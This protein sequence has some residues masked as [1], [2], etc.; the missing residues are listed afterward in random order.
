MGNGVSTVPGWYG[1]WLSAFGGADSGIWRIAEPGAD[2]AVPYRRDRLHVGLFEIAVAAAAA[3][4]HT[5]YYDILGGGPG[6]AHAL[7]RMMCD[8]NVD[9]L[10]FPYLRRNSRLLTAL[11]EGG[12]R[13]ALEHCEFAPFVDCDDPW[14]TYWEGRGKKTRQ[15]WLRHER[16]LLE[17][18]CECVCL[19]TV[20]E[21]EAVFEE[22]LT[23]E[24]SG[25]KGAG[26]TAISQ[27]HGAEE[28]YRMLVRHWAEQGWLRLFLMRDSGGEIVAFQL[29]A[30]YRGVVI[31]LKI[32]QLAAY[33]R[34]SP[35]QVLQLQIL[36]RLFEDPEVGIYDLLG[37]ATAHKLRW[38]TGR[39]ELRTLRIF[40]R[41]PRGEL[42]RVR[43]V[44]AP[45]WKARLRP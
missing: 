25:W 19:E 11:G 13:V 33:D 27:E 42:A 20:A 23:V 44:V 38:A 35:G 5:P 39:E 41:S 7:R 18:G 32:G 40:R 24:A 34:H 12:R 45:R 16:R 2:L 8:L 10:V 29:C 36:R 17:R 3:N 9:M 1:I 26:G 43:F 15:E 22:V 37:P 4:A 28:F 31:S 21:A 14:K 6:V 30:R